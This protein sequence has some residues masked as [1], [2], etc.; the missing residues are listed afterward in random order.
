MSETKFAPNIVKHPHPFQ[1]KVN[2]LA[3]AKMLL[4]EWV[5]FRGNKQVVFSTPC[6]YG[7]F[8]G[9]VGGFSPREQLCVGCLRCTTQ[10]PKVVTILHNPERKSL[11]DSYFHPLYVDTI[12]NEAQKGQVP[13]K[14]QGYRG[15]FGGDGWDG[16]WTDMSEIVRPTRDGIHGREYIS[17]EVDIGERPKSLTFDEKGQL[18]DALPHTLP[19]SIPFL[20]DVPP[21]TRNKQK[22]LVS[23]LKESAEQIGTLAII[24]FE[25]MV[26][27][28]LKDPH[29]VP[30]IHLSEYDA[31][32][33]FG[34]EPKMLELSSW[35][36]SVFQD[37]RKRY[38]K[39]LIA[40]R[41]AFDELD[42]LDCYRNGARIF[43][44]TADY[45]GKG[46]DDQF[47][48]NLIR[49]SH[50]IFVKAGVR[51]EVSL[52][53]SGGIIAAEHLPKALIAG[54]DAICLDTT[55]MVALQ[56]KFKGECSDPKKA[57]F[58]LPDELN[59]SWGVER[60]K[61][62]SVAWRNQL[63]EILGAMG[64]RDVKRITG[65]MGRALFQKELEKE[66]FSKIVGYEK[67]KS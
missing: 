48:F 63:L 40:I 9:P 36:E 27:Y 20:F 25:S 6:V 58:E 47:I 57:L 31:F 16:I 45:H 52:I 33:N 50:L 43:H 26:Q 10:Y 11:G 67:R 18:C 62:L 54:L 3:L 35:S 59:S 7:V 5:H 38:P 1:V 53:G 41:S 55:V 49:S 24:P 39:T 19:L 22:E 8:S 14:G 28:S 29:I 42:L 15:P 66:A 23:I 2:K 34:F 56:A 32:K 4:K 30:L 46:K 21:K 65:E 13:I 64:I 37:I 44:L 60:L 61:N 17:T 51:S 12:V